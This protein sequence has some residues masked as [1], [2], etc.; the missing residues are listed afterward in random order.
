MLRILLVFVGLWLA[1]AALY[2]QPAI[3]QNGVVNAAS[4]IP[5]SFAGG[6]IGRGALFTISGVRL[7]DSGHVAVTLSKN[8]VVSPVEVLK[9]TDRRIDAWM[10]ASA[11]LGSAMLVV[12]AG[13]ESSKPIAVNV[14]EF[15]PGLFS[16]NG[17]GWGPALADNIEKSG[18]RFANSPTRPAHP[19]QRVVLT[20]T[21]LA[22]A[23]DVTVMLG[24][25]TIK[26]GL[27]KSLERGRE[28]ITVVIPSD[29]PVGCWV[30]VYIL[31][32]PARASN[33]VTLTIGPTAP[34]RSDLIPVHSAQRIGVVGLSRA[35][36][37]TL[38]KKMRLDQGE[39]VLDD[40]RISF[41]DTGKDTILTPLRLLP[42][43]GTCTA[44][45]ASFQANADLA[46][47][48]TSIVS[49]EGRGLDAGSSLA[50]S[51]GE[52]TKSIGE[53]WETP[54]RYRARLGSS[55]VP[56]LSSAPPL[57]LFP[58]EYV[59]KGPGGKDVG[60][61]T[62]KFTIPP[63][64][65]WTDRDAIPAVD[66]SRGVT[67][68][69][70]DESVNDLVL[71]IARNVDQVATTIGMTI[72]AVRAES[73][74]Y[75]IPPALLANIPASS[76]IPGESFDE[77]AVAALASRAPVRASGLNS[78]IVMMVSLSQRFVQYR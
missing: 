40:A 58:G 7:Q 3:S 33:V 42:P 15:N 26:S 21:G 23:K 38:E 50:L 31:V 69:W 60:A 45:T 5:S 64:L 63:P 1:G 67:V 66:R 41:I 46:T 10:P 30:P 24:N 48:I 27:T 14:S 76:N 6:S 19:G 29:A 52:Q 54:G 32:T 65:E 37:K 44:Y 8:G 35:R 43:P 2:A 4:L 13:G 78:G 62:A 70:K 16:R 47:S 72:C 71:I 55:G 20:A 34:C 59:L 36:L 73:N 51:R 57:F 77:L 74:Q 56:N 39:T 28:E 68:H 17:A 53:G 49:P 11:P 25:Q 9:A 18:L 22:R 75:S 61:F 12:T